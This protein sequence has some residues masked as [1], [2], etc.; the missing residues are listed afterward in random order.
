MIKIKKYIILKRYNLD[1]WGLL[2]TTIG[3]RLKLI[4]QKFIPKP[5]LMMKLTR[6]R[7]ISTFFL[8]K[9]PQKVVQR[10]FTISKKLDNILR[11][12]IF[13]YIEKWER[14]ERKYQRYIY[15]IDLTERAVKRR[16]LN[17]DFINIRIIKYFYINLDYKDFR[18]MAKKAK[19]MDSSFGANY[20]LILEGRAVCMVYRSGF[21]ANM[22][23]AI[24]VVNLGLVWV[25]KLQK[26]YITNINYVIKVN[27]I[28]G[29]RAIFKSTIYWKWAKRL[30]RKS[31][32]YTIP[33]YMFISF[34]FL[35]FFNKY[36]PKANQIINPIPIDI[37]RATGYANLLK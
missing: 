20:V 31:L 26:L 23:E 2:K 11:F 30:S 16:K 18:R 8:K 32:L 15:R 24:K 29:F 12:F 4:K 22:F 33:K 27:E 28:V 5:K 21:I 13:K 35:I 6:L 19:K 10:E 17:I 37:Y 34:Y 3:L 25:C 36:L 1:I 7:K 9:V 14:R